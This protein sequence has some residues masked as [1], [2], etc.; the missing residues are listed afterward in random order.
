MRMRDPAGY[1]SLLRRSINRG[2]MDA[3]AGSRPIRI[4]SAL[5][6]V[7]TAGGKRVRPAMVLLA[8]EGVGGKRRDAFAASIA[9]ELLHSFT[10]VHDDIMDNAPTRRGR[11]TV[12][13]QWDVSHGIL[14][15]DVLLGLA[16]QSLLRT[17]KGNLSAITGLFT[18][19]LL[20]VCEGQS[21]DLDFEKKPN[22]S[23]AAYFRMIEKKTAALFA[24]SA[25]IGGLIAGGS[26]S[27]VSALARYGHHLGRAFQIQDDLLDVVAEEQTFGKIVG[28]D[29]VEGKKT[30]LLLHAARGAKG[31]DRSLLSGILKGESGTRDTVRA[32]TRIYQDVGSTRAA[33]VRIQYETRRAKHALKSLSVNRGRTMLEWIAD[34]LASRR[35]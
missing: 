14:A 19:A 20:D 2:L 5:R 18:R 12:H 29:I 27:Q 35:F 15:G 13:T 7:L 17:R 34:A 28:G 24:L 9:V 10:L 21:V 6:H 22:V 8:A 32:V 33:E 26:T 3:A 30:F 31:S 23:L 4:R 11:P 25:T 16:Y 1:Y